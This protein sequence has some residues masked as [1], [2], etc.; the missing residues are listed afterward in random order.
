MF[1]VAE[2]QRAST[3]LFRN[4]L[5]IIMK[6]IL[7]KLHLAHLQLHLLNKFEFLSGLILVERFWTE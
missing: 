2:M 7:K 1:F 4:N 6:R 5:T 3:Y